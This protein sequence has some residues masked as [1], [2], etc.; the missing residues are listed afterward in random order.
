MDKEQIR[1]A[2]VLFEMGV[3]EDIIQAITGQHEKKEKP[4][5][6]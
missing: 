5:K 2:E 6:E 4:S 3:D 1:I